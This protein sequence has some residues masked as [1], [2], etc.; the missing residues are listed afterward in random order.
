MEPPDERLEPLGRVDRDQVVAQQ[1]AELQDAVNGNSEATRALAHA[2][3]EAA[4]ANDHALRQAR[5]LALIALVIAIVS[6]ATTVAV[7]L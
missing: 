4:R 2:L 3:E 1:I 6:L 7:L 5:R